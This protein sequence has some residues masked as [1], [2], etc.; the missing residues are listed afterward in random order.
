VATLLVNRKVCPFTAPLIVEYSPA[1]EQVEIVTVVPDA[2]IVADPKLEVLVHWLWA[3][4]PANKRHENSKKYNF[5]ISKIWLIV[6]ILLHLEDNT[7]GSYDFF[8]LWQV[9]ARKYSGQKCV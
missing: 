9:L 8:P 4:Y 5:F 2:L 3:V 1:K 6:N 7:G